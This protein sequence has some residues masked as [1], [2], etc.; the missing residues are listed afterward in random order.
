MSDLLSDL[1][2]IAK[3]VFVCDLEVFTFD[4]LTLTLC[5]KC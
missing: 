4:L 1:F 3:G 5:A 2:I